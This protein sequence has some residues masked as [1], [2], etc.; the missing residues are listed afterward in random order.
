MPPKTTRIPPVE[1]GPRGTASYEIP[2]EE[3]LNRYSQAGIN[4][5]ERVENDGLQVAEDRPKLAS[6]EYFDGRMPINWA[7]LSNRE[8]GDLFEMLTGHADYVG[9]KVVLAK[10]LMT[11]ASEK[12]ELT[13]AKIRKSYTGTSEERLDSTYSDTRYVEVNAEWLE[14]KEYFEILTGIL[15]A[16]DRDIRLLSRHIEVKKIDFGGTHRAGSLTGQRRDR[17]SRP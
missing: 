2:L 12:L 7:G 13:K 11:N 8:I 14:A 10:V 4:A 9:G 3:G 5:M 17:F 1:V 15:S 16:A 6:G